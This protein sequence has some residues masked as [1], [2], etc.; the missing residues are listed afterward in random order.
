MNF[1]EAMHGT[2]ARELVHNLLLLGHTK[3]SD[4]L[5]AYGAQKEEQSRL[6]ELARQEFL[7]QEQEEGT[8]QQQ[9]NG[10]LNGVNSVKES[11]IN[12]HIPDPITAD[13]GQLHTA[14]AKLFDAGLVERVIDSMFRS[15]ADI[16]DELEK[17]LAREQSG[18]GV[19]TAKQKLEFANRLK[20]KFRDLRK[21]GT[22]WRPHSRKRPFNGEHTNGVNGTSKRR[23][24][25][26]GAVNGGS[27]YDDDGSYLDVGLRSSRF[28]KESPC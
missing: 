18:G 15:P 25:S 4:L 17:D 10:D 22:E 19:K 9:E 24:L 14:L 28:E 3:I 20:H 11:R 2:L 5:Q 16:Q 6:A 8:A 27:N 7:R 13:T 1:V 23:R 21:E 12:D 26:S